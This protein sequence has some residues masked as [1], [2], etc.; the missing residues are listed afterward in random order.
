MGT[1]LKSYASFIGRARDAFRRKRRPPMEFL[2][3]E[4][5]KVDIRM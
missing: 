5:F 2:D 1:K 4:L 3:F